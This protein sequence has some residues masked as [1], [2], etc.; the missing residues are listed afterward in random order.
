MGHYVFKNR[1]PQ[2]VIK[3]SDF[4][5]EVSLEDFLGEIKS[6]PKDVWLA[7]NPLHQDLD[8]LQLAL[9]DLTNNEHTVIISDVGDRIIPWKLTMP[10]V[11]FELK[12]NHNFNYKNYRK[13][14]PLD[15]VAFEDIWEAAEY[16]IARAKIEHIQRESL[17]K[18]RFKLQGLWEHLTAKV[19]DDSLEVIVNRSV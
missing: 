18:C 10:G 16:E 9:T 15:T 4:E 7:G 12:A 8:F 17:S 14:G 6:F 11:R 2:T 19:L 5:A 1:A 3:F 13:L